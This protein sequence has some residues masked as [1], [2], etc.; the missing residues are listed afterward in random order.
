MRVLLVEDE[1]QLAL[2]V[3]RAVERAGHT[4]RVEHDGKAGLD[5]IFAEEPDLV[6]LDI[7]LPVM[8]GLDVL[9]T[10]RAQRAGSPLVLM[11]TA[12]SDVDTRVQSL[13]GGADDYLSKPFAMEELVARILAL[14]RRATKESKGSVLVVGD[15]SLDVAHRRVARGA[16][17]IDLSPRELDLLQV[18]MENPARVFSRTELCQL[19]WRRKDDDDTRIVEMFIARLRKKVDT[20][21][22]PPLIHTV[23]GVGYCVSAQP[24]DFDHAP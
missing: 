7:N 24:S 17:E 1:K 9:R 20:R 18:F 19:V 21:A 11:L 14:G 15:L 2:L 6:L 3:A 23:R 5:A 16:R 8:N 13:E 4:V 12:N 22:D 10:L